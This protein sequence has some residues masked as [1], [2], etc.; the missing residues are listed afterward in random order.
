[1]TTRRLRP[2]KLG[3][4]G[5]STGGTSAIVETDPN[6]VRE[7]T[8]EE[9][10]PI[11]LAAV[12]L[13]FL[14]LIISYSRGYLLLYGDAVAHLGI[15]RRI[16]D[17]RNPG[18]VQFGGVWL[19]LPHLLMLP[20][21]QKMEWWQNGLAGAFPSLICY[22]ASVAGLYRLAR[23]MMTPRW[24]IAAT[25]FYAFNPNLLYLATTA[26]NE[27]LFLAI[28]IWTILLTVECVAGIQAS[29]PTVVARRL[30]LL[31][32]FILAAVF[33]RYD[34]WILGAAVWCVLTMTLA[35]HRDVWRGVAP[36]FVVF[37]LLAAAGPISWLAF[38]EHFFHDPLDFLRGPYSAAAIDRKTS[39]P[40]AAHYHGWHNPAWALL[41]YI[42]TAQIDVAVWETGFLVMA[43][44]LAGLVLAIRRKLALPALLLWL[45]LPFYVYSISYGSVPIFIP[46]LW[47]HSYYNSRYGME[48]LPALV[49]FSVLIMDWAQ[50]RWSK[51]R[52]LTARFFQPVA[53]LL[54]AVNAVCMMRHLPVVL[55]EAVVN[56]TTRVAFET[57]LA[58][59]LKDLPTGVPILMYN[60]DHVGA[61]QDAGLP[62]RQTVN[63]GDYDS[64]KAAL[65]APAEHAAYVVAIAGDQV[66]SAVAVHPEGLTELSILCTTGQ[67]CARIY[68][69]DRFVPSLATPRP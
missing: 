44:A 23:W 14:A 10:F 34:G 20:F 42:R 68:R 30:L 56:S 11:A 58:R 25:A 29:R 49:V 1:L 62:L 66:S 65:A 28:F 55:K 47:P 12:L 21:V 45:P 64:W 19:P 50:I 38:N 37:T 18:L 3:A 9:T 43:S 40:G 57:A 35:R 24:A 36:F 53:L 17:S 46:P 51:S 32:L 13:A 22:I 15:A 61:L 2:A 48:M 6:E 8:R 4:A 5:T 16:L 69:S 7:A 54:I 26:M 59:E 27:A 60:S 33:T 63:E 67:P 52:P 41:L 31:G 39:L